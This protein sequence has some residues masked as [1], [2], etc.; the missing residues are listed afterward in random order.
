MGFGGPAFIKRLGNKKNAVRLNVVLV[1]VFGLLAGACSANSEADDANGGQDVEGELPIP[2]ADRPDVGSAPEDL[3][4][5]G[6]LTLPEGVQG[7]LEEVPGFDELADKYPEAVKVIR[8][9]DLTDEEDFQKIYDQLRTIQEQEG[10]DGLHQF[11]L[12]TGLLQNL[13]LDTIYTELVIN[14]EEGGW[15]QTREFAAQRGLI[16]QDDQLRIIL[17]LESD[18]DSLIGPALDELGIEIIGTNGNQIEAGIELDDL[19]ALES[20]DELFVFLAEVAQLPS[21]VKV[22]FP[23]TSVTSRV[24]QQTQS[25]T[26]LGEGP[27]STGANNWHDAGIVGEGIKVGVIDPD[28]FFGY[29]QLLGTDLPSAERISFMPGQ[30]PRDLAQLTGPHG[31]ACAEIVYEMAPGVELY[32]AHSTSTV[33]FA[34][35]IDWMIESGV[36]IITYS[37]GRPSEPIDGSG[38]SGIHV[39]RAIDAGILWVN[40]SG[41]FGQAHLDMNY[42]DANGN[43]FHEFP[44]GDEVLPVTL[45]TDEIL[46]SLVWD[47]VWVGSQRNYDLVL[48]QENATGELEE[49]ASSRNVQAGSLGDN[50]SEQ[51]ATRLQGDT[52]FLAISAPQPTAGN[53]L[54]L[55]GNGMD[56][57]YSIP[58]GSVASPA[59][60]ETVLSVGAVNWSDGVLEPYSSQGP[61]WDG[62]L[63]PN[64]VAPARVESASFQ[65]QFFGTSSSAP[66]VAGSA[67]LLLEQNPQLSNTELRNALLSNAVDQ[68]PTGSDNQTGSGNLNL[69]T[70][71]SQFDVGPST[72]GPAERSV[73]GDNQPSARLENLEVREASIDGNPALEVEVDVYLQNLG[74]QEVQVASFFFHDTNRN[75]P[76]RDFNGRYSSQRNTV[77][78]GTKFIAETEEQVVEGVQLTIPLSEL[79]LA[80]EQRYELKITTSVSS[81]QAWADYLTISEWTQVVLE[82]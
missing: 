72:D 14:Y 24:W 49:V 25:Q 30:N 42:T 6:D 1:V 58:E 48:L 76:L 40:S 75:I 34:N 61:T 4:I 9:S 29:D 47:D 15:S 12:G 19:E 31:T 36:D 77:A 38:P 3:E 55:L 45:T 41:N 11:M 17:E 50:P 62:R 5:V 16:N 57:Q 60:L 51:I 37:A 26:V 59:D 68:G 20:S 33:S 2:G 44:S 35:A 80:S 74:S 18:D 64:I 53:R 73:D 52:A 28:G 71:P 67:A 10:S 78:V 81:E 54:N 79:H 70:D 82:T 46:A 27:E 23:S 63:K 65:G 43:G 39:Q 66:H 32:L 21:V 7:D 22:K 8:E 56:F 69:G 13:G